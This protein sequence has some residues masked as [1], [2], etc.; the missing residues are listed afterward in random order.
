MTSLNGWMALGVAGQVCF[1]LRFLVQWITSE[2][3]GSS[4]IPN[5]FWYYSVIGG[6][7]VLA[8]AMHTGDPVF[9]LAYSF[10]V[11]IYVRNIMLIAGSGTMTS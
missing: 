8:Y 4:T 6:I 3:K 1:S 9:I 11:L 2:K 7:M 5:S 10:N